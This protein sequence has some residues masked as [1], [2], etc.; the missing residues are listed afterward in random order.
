[1]LSERSCSLVS[2]WPRIPA[3]DAASPSISARVSQLRV[4]GFRF[5]DEGLGFR[6]WIEG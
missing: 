4:E 1:V 6:V 3:S 2:P 5:M